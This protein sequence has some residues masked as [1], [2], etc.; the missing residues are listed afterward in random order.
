M[1]EKHRPDA[2]RSNTGKTLHDRLVNQELPIIFG[3]GRNEGKTV[4]REQNRQLVPKR[5][6]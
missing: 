6:K 4:L 1:Y 5:Y 3:G 2:G